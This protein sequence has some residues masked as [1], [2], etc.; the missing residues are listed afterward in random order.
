LKWP[1]NRFKSLLTKS[2]VPEAEEF[3]GYRPVKPAKQKARHRKTRDWRH[4]CRSRLGDINVS[5]LLES[6]L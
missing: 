4:H 6:L 2:A 1:F 3:Q 5:M